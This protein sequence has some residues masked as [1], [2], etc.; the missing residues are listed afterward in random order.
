MA[1]QAVS[2]LDNRPSQFREK[3][4]KIVTPKPIV[5]NGNEVK[6]NPRSRSAKMR[7]LEKIK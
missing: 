1:G 5:P 2:L 3:L 6:F 7:T 4:A